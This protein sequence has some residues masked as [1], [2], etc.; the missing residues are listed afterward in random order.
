MGAEVV[1][2]DPYVPEYRG[3]LKEKAVGCQAAVVMVK[4]REYT[5]LDLGK[6][7]VWLSTPV[8]VDARRVFAQGAADSAGFIHREIGVGRSHS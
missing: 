8:L 5:N 7:K 3:S 1:I 6:L 2:H 4:H